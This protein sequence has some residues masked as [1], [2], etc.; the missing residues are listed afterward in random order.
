MTDRREFVCASANPDKV[1]ELAAI[2]DG[3]GIELLPRPTDVPE[4]AED[5]RTLVDN[6]RR[7]A[8]ALC[9]ATGRPAIADDTGLEVDALDGRPGV[10]AAVYAGP[11]ATYA[12]NVSKLL[13][14]LAAVGAVGPVGRAARFRT[15]AFVA[16]PDGREAI[17]EG[18]VEGWIT[19]AARGG[20][21]GYD[22]VFAVGDLG[23]RTF[24]EVDA[25]TKHVVSHRGRAFR[26]L[27][28]LLDT[29]D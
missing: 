29:I 8:V 1:A 3:V 19:E 4:V 2:L 13:G 27:A 22:P 7:K 24:G 15:V 28:E 21:W 18:V 25:V 9:R 14:E 5:G 12:E 17:A 6:A 11:R 16:W 20:G 26:R 23:G 10:D